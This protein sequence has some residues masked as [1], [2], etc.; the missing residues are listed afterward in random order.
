MG[1]TSLSR[2]PRGQP[3][4]RVAAA[5]VALVA[6]LAAG[7][8]IS[9]AAPRA[10]AATKHTTHRNVTKHRRLARLTLR[11]V[12]TAP[13]T[14]GIYPGGAAGT[15]GPSGQTKP[16]DPTKRLAA[17]EQ[18][19][20]GDRPFV[21]HL[22]A[23]YTGPLGSSAAAQ[24]GEDIARYTANGFQIELVLTYRPADRNATT[25][26][27]G[28]VEFV[29]DTV[30]DLGSNQGLTSL[31]VTN[32]ANIPGVPNASDGDYPGVE[33]AL[34]RGVIAAKDEIRR[35]GFGQVRVGF[36]WCY[37]LGPAEL[38]FWS[39][40]AT[41]GGHAFVQALDWLGLDI[42]PGTWGPKLASDSLAS[43][44]RR[45]T[46]DSLSVLRQRY[47]PL[48]GIPA[49]V[50]IHIS[51]SGYPTGPG[52]TDAMQMTALAAGVQAVSDSRAKFNVSDYRWFD[53]RDANSADSSFESQ[54]GL[55]HDDYTPKPA[56]VVYKTLIGELAPI[57]TVAS[58]ARP[59]RGLGRH[60]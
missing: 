55:M 5:F 14:F 2:S 44:V 25:D 22:Y 45:A 11:S 43:G 49:T 16:E 34:I 19:R 33:D 28:F 60:R 50:P 4:R 7:W 6:V 20:G 15:S 53:L 56:F 59:R 23:S 52:R 47:M 46:L 10:D 54:Y 35:D 40:L 17:L 1:Q 51:E 8:V 39:Y 30:R 48:A 9:L 18:L 26:V 3:A 12:A 13:L 37:S 42:Y 29:R 21:L 36:N 32:E 24:V 57:A 31:Q 41:D 58:R 38:S 27:G